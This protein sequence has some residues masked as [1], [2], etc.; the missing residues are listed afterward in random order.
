MLNL[1]E[2]RSLRSADSPQLRRKQLAD[3][4][5]ELK[6]KM[7]L[8]LVAMGLREDIHICQ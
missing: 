5:A 2:M 6:L 4:M 7:T 8:Q 3:M 1:L